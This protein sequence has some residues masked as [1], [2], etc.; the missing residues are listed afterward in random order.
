M[1]TPIVS[2]YQSPVIAWYDALNTLMSDDP[3]FEEMIFLYHLAYP[4]MFV[5]ALNAHL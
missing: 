1:I 4:E 3:C 5:Q 2:D